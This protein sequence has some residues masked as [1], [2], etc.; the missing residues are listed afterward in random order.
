ML[1]KSADDKS[2]RIALFEDLKNSPMLDSWQKDRLRDELQKLRRGIQGE[3]DSAHYLNNYFKDSPNHAVIHDLRIE[4]EGEVAQIDHLLINRVLDFYMLETK[5][6]NGDVTITPHGE[7][8]VEYRGENVYNIPSPIEQS[9]RHENVLRRLF[10]KLEISGRAG[11]AP[12]F[13]HV[14]L[15][16]P[17]AAI[18]RPDQKRFDSSMVIRADQFRTWQ[19]EHIDRHI[20]TTELLTSMLNLRGPDAVKEI[21]EKIKRQ[22]R[23]ENVLTIPDW[24]T[25][26]A[27]ATP[28]HVAERVTTPPYSSLQS[29]P[30]AK[31]DE[32]GRKKLVCV[33][34][35]CKISYA[36][37]KFCWNNEKRFN[38]NQYCR[39]HQAAFC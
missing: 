15:V 18:H 36:E 14:V 11:T 9:K 2:K 28:I 12:H 26:K 23:P 13:K 35:N 17:K 10:T 32:S 3:K 7:F 29:I 8:S 25:P 34:C 39:N 30:P 4:V 6:F 31:V 21:A 5:N 16:D 22:H 20:G 19:E 1:I 33:T 27:K 38:G 37:G 24:L